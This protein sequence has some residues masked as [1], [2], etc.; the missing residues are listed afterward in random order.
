MKLQIIHFSDIHFRE[1]NNSLIN[2]LDKLIDSIL[3]EL[4]NANETIILITGDSAFSGS[5]KEFVIAND[6]FGKIIDAVNE[7][8]K[9]KVK[10]I[11]VPGNHDCSR[12]TEVDSVRE[13]LLEKFQNSPKSC[14]LQL[15]NT[16]GKN[17]DNY[18][19]F[20]SSFNQNTYSNN[21]SILLK[22]FEFDVLDK[23][24]IFYCYNTSFQSV[25]KEIPG[26]MIFPI[27]LIPT[28]IE[29][30]SADLR[31]SC[32]H[33]PL[34]WFEPDNRREFKALIER[35]SDVFFT[36]HEHVDG[37]YQIKDLISKNNIY[38]IEG[39]VLQDSVDDEKSGYNLV[40]FNLCEKSFQINS[41]KWEKNKYVKIPNEKISFERSRKTINNPFLIED[42]FYFKLDENGAN[43]S[44]PNRE[45]VK[46]S[47]VFVYPNLELLK[48]VDDGEEQPVVIT[49]SSAELF[50]KEI[51]EADL[52]IRIIISGAENIGKTSL[53]K[54]Y[55]LDLHSRGLVPIF[56]DGIQIKSTSIDDFK[57]LLVKNFLQQYSSEEKEDIEQLDRSKLII[58]IDDF[59]KVKVNL[60]YKARLLQNLIAYFPNIIIAGN[61]LMS[62][63]DI[64][65]DESSSVDLY[66]SFSLYELKEFGFHLKG[67]LINKWNT[68]GVEDSI[69]EEERIKKLHNAEM[70]VNTVTGINFVPSYP[71]F[72][73]TILQSIELGNPTDLSASTFGHYYQFLIQKSFT[74]I[75]SSQRQITEYENYLSEFSFY[76]L[77]NSL[78]EID[79]YEFESFDSLYREKY[80]ISESFETIV[81]N[82]VK[83]K[84]IEHL[85]GVYEY[86]YSY[87]HYYFV[88]N[89]LSNHI[90]ES[91]IKTIIS[92]LSERLYKSEFSNIILFLTHHSRDKFLLQ[93][94][95]EKAQSIFKD[96]KPCKLQED[97]SKL[98]ELGNSIPEL[99]YK[100]RSI[101]EYR[102]EENKLKDEYYIEVRNAELIEPAQNIYDEL[103]DELNAISNL[104]TG[105][106]TI[107]I[108]GQILKNNYGKIENSQIEK[109][110]EE[111]ILLGLR[112]LNM[113][114][115]IIE[116]NS[117]YVINQVNSIIEEIEIARG[118]KVDN[119]KKIEVSA[120]KIEVLSKT[121]LFGLCSQIS[122]S[123]IKKISDSV[124]TEHLKA[125]SEKVY[126]KH[127]YN[128]V[129]LLKL[130]IKLDHFEGFP[131]SEIKRLSKEFSDSRLSLFVM[132]RMV[133]N[134]LYLY[135]TNHVQK[136]KILSFL[137][138]PV[139]KQ[140]RI[141]QISKQ[142]K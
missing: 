21:S 68:L 134:Y 71:F 41:F 74:S 52:D 24:V 117:E 16:I 121:T 106:K 37:G 86:K 44:H 97:I 99:V 26:K 45:V 141:D 33:H 79:R 64:I 17:L 66:S 11:I 54:R 105:F 88:S 129:K 135:P 138:I 116:E 10:V 53:L 39:D 91:K 22:T 75:L 30:D 103:D 80:T 139:D 140:L 83:G 63:E 6:F 73:L 98:N 87:V 108:V 95:L 128:S 51:I 113:F 9:C 19:E 84:I 110:L 42:K 48:K 107:E 76:L 114:F 59:N 142:K 20:E 18:Y 85:D 126:A 124:G 4:E 112:S 3:N 127:D 115:G 104:N 130:A 123:F 5:K 77:E 43:F 40:N 62:L 14:D 120:K 60:R 65:L 2:K 122:Y 12:L 109:L 36:G 136:N 72:I 7:K 90:D 58:I 131:D 96:L 13:I 35:N 28:E 102:E 27:N 55:F 31:V 132:K 38:H 93:K 137:N 56:F 94:L 15:V 111:T 82:L 29:S 78:R 67:K 81:K 125:I 133:V 8:A 70:T 49:L 89:Y 46:L 1:N 61:E 25:L 50:K 101:D 118:K 57:K 119:P 34:N 100:S 69:S 92:R 32:F 47:D 23:K